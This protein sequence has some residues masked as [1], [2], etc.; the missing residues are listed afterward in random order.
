MTTPIAAINLRKEPAYRREAFVSGLKRVGYSAVCMNKTDHW[1]PK[2]PQDLLVVWNLKRG[3]DEE[4]AKTW[5]KRGGTV[6]VTEN[7]YL[8]KV[9]KSSYAI[10]THGHNGSG[11]FPVSDEDRFNKLG[12]EIKP[13]RVAAGM[14]LVCGQ[15]G[16][17]SALM[18]SPPQW[19][20]KL[21]KKL[22]HAR[23]RPHPGNFKPKVPLLTDLEHVGV[24]HVWSS[25][26]GIVAL[27]EGVSTTHLAP[28]WICEG[29]GG[30]L[31]DAREAALN[32]MAHSQWSVAEIESGEPFARMQA[33]N[34]GPREW[35]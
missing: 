8:Q 19:G 28:H 33:H 35:R 13:W 26:A 25:S 16:I 2:G 34:W 11:W 12:Y 27:L 29:A 20:E 17:G 1:Q 3:R 14:H 7:A 15:R 4:D 18:A 31:N 24:C 6:I 9:D 30:P 22:V 32:R 23:L 5:E 10:S 21:V